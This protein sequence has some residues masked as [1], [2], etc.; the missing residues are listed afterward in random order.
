MAATLRLTDVR[1]LAP[2]VARCRRLLDLDAD[3]EAV[4]ATLAADP[5]LTAAVDKEPGVR[6][7][8]A[9]D[10]FEMAVRA[11]VGQQVSVAGAR[12]VLTRLI[13]AAN[14]VDDEIAPTTDGSGELRLRA[15][16]S[17]AEVLALP[18][19]AFGMP[20][21]RRETIRTV[22]RAVADGTLDLDPGADREQ[23]TA[24]LTGLPG[25]GPWTAAYVLLRAVG[26]PDAF[27]P[28]DLGVRHGATALGL[29]DAPAALADHASRWRPGVPTPRSDS[30]E[31]LER[32]EQQH[33]GTPR[34]AR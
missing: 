29:P 20:A 4:D 5:A 9:V 26:D 21:A 14:P 27:L 19:Q 6:V 18:D 34:P 10:G 16:P 25:I 23:L 11:I 13:A 32:V 28:T 2:A 31:Q 30:G 7:P 15:F 17:A 33:P 24:Q 22:A 12:T 3:P 8:R 1:D